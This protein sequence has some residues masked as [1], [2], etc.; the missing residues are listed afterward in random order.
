MLSSLNKASALK[1]ECRTSSRAARGKRLHLFQGAIYAAPVVL[2]TIVAVFP[3]TVVLGTPVIL[4]ALKELLNAHAIKASYDHFKKAQGIKSKEWYDG[5]QSMHLSALWVLSEKETYSTFKDKL[6][7]LLPRLKDKNTQER[8]ALRFGI[9]QQLR[10]LALHGPTEQ[11]RQTSTKQLSTLAQGAGW[12]DNQ[13]VMEGLLDSLAAIAKHGQEISERDHAKNS[14]KRLTQMPTTNHKRW[15]PL[16]LR[17]RSKIY[18]QEA[19][20][21]LGGQSL[22]DKLKGIPPRVVAPITGDL[23]RTINGLL[24]S[25]VIELPVPTNAQAVLRVSREPCHQLDS[26][27]IPTQAIAPSTGGYLGI[28]L[29]SSEKRSQYILAFPHLLVHFQ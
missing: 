11:V 28:S 1:R 12:E 27:Q 14:L 10:M 2:G 20:E 19:T 23:F 25:K 24:R 17:N 26:L 7:Q 13:E 6:E 29:S 21:W 15:S 18:A 8:Q 4:G 9:V 16:R 3:P 22:D 5:Y